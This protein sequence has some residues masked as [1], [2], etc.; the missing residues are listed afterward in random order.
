MSDPAALERRYRALLACYPADHRRTYGEEMIGVLLT[1]AP[2]GTTR[3][4]IADTADLIGGGIRARSRRLRSA[5]G[6]SGGAWRDALAALSILAPVLVLA[7]LASNYVSFLT[8]RS[9]VEPRTRM[10]LPFST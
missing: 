1:S 4:S 5:D 6:G 7:Q 9:A 3:P 2:E 10:P 8:L